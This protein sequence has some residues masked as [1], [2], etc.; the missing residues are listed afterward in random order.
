MQQHRRFIRTAIAVSYTGIFMIFRS[1]RG[2]ECMGL[3]SKFPVLLTIFSLDH[4]CLQTIILILFWAFACL[5]F[6]RG[7]LPATTRINPLRHMLSIEPA[8]FSKI[9]ETQSI[10]AWCEHH[11]QLTINWDPPLKFKISRVHN[12]V[13]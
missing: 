4:L 10:S 6:R 5:I 7:V 12:D 2:T 1:K 9:S 3:H 8:Y 11:G 13:T